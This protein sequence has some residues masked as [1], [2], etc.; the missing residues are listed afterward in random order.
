M[1]ELSSSNQDAVLGRRLGPYVL[2]RKIASGGMGTVY[3][4]YHERLE[5]EVALKTLRPDQEASNEDL[6]RFL[7]EAR[8]AARLNHPN[9]V[10]VFDVGEDGGV[11]YLAMELVR[12]RSL[13]DKLRNEGRLDPREAL[14]IVAAACD[15]LQHAHD[16]GILHRDLKPANLLLHAPSGTP[17]ITD[18]GVA[19]AQGNK[20]LT[21]TGVA[22]GTPNYMSPEQAMGKNDSLDARSDVWG[23]G[24]ILYELLTGLPPFNRASQLET[25]Q[26]VVGEALVPP[27]VHR[28]E[29]SA[30]VEAIVLRCLSKP[31]EHRYP[32]AFELAQDLR[33]SLRGERIAARAEAPRGSRRLLAALILAVC[34]GLCLAAFLGGIYVGREREQAQAS[35]APT[36]APAGPLRPED[37]LG[38]LERRATSDA[39]DAELAD[40]ERA[41]SAPSYQAAAEREGRAPL[42]SASVFQAQA[43]PLLAALRLRRAEAAP[44]TE[45]LPRLSL[46]AKAALAAP[47]S[48]P[49]R[50][51]WLSLADELSRGSLGAQRLAGEL[52]EALSSGGDPLA[53]EAAGRAA[54]LA[55]DAFEFRD[56]ARLLALAEPTP[57]NALRRE[58]TLGLAGDT[59]LEG[60]LSLFGQSDLGPCLI[61]AG[62]G[63]VRIRALE[64]EV[65]LSWP[66]TPSALASVDLSGDGVDELFLAQ[67]GQGG[68]S[69]SMFSIN[70]KDPAPVRRIG[71][72]AGVC[73]ELAGGSLSGDRVSRKDLLLVADQAS[74]TS[75]LSLGPQG[76]PKTRP[77]FAPGDAPAG[78]WHRGL[79]L[80]LDGERG[81]EVV[82][83]GWHDASH[84][85][86]P[87]SQFV[88]LRRMGAEGT[89]STLLTRL[90]VGQVEDL[91]AAPSK[92]LVAVSGGPRG[93]GVSV[94]GRGSGPL[95]EVLGHWPIEGDASSVEQ[96]RVTYFETAAGTPLLLRAYARAGAWALEA[97]P[98]AE[99]LAGSPQARVVSEAPLS[100]QRAVTLVAGEADG[101][102]GFELVIGRHVFGLRPPTAPPPAPAP[103]DLG[104]AYAALRI[105]GGREAAEELLR[106]LPLLGG[107]S[108]TLRWLEP[109]QQ[110]VRF[111]RA[112]AQGEFKARAF[113]SARKALAEAEARDRGLVTDVL[114]GLDSSALPEERWQLRR[115]GLEAAKRLRDWPL[116]VKVLRD[117][118]RA[119]RR[120]GGEH[121]IEW[122]ARVRGWSRLHSEEF[123]LSDTKRPYA[124]SNPYRARFGP[125]GV[126]LGVDPHA[127][128]AAFVALDLGSTH[129][130]TL[131]AELELQGGV[132][133]G[134]VQCG[135]IERG[136]GTQSQV[137]G[138]EVW[139]YNR[140]SYQER[141]GY[142]RFMASGEPVSDWIELHELR[143]KLRVKLALRT[144]A[145]GIESWA[146]V[147]SGEALIYEGTQETRAAR[148]LPQRA[149]LGILATASS[150]NYRE[151]RRWAR[152]GTI[153]LARIA[154][155]TPRPAQL[156]SAVEPQAS[157]G[158]VARGQYSE[159][160]KALDAFLKTS[161]ETLARAT[162]LRSR[163]LAKSRLGRADEALADLEQA[164]NAAPLRS[165]WWLELLG[166]ELSP[167]E[168]PLIEALLERLATTQHEVGVAMARSLRGDLWAELP[169]APPRPLHAGV[170][171][172]L[173]YRRAE[174]DPKERYATWQTYQRL[175]GPSSSFLPWERFPTVLAPRSAPLA[176]EEYE[177]LLAA[178]GSPLRRYVALSRAIQGR[179]ARGA[180]RLGLAR[181]F[182]EQGLPGEAEALLRQSEERVP[183]AERGQVEVALAEVY[184]A[185]DD[186]PV[187]AEFLERAARRGLPREGWP[188]RFPRLSKDPR[189][190]KLFR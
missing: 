94:I 105:L 6:A 177:A 34:L 150:L 159:A 91:A 15:G 10:P 63:E 140:E 50:R 99:V 129:L 185:L 67:A 20:R 39:D 183:E 169:T 107:A 61:S 26:A 142:L 73:Y 123:L 143:G 4:A 111:S 173:G 76:Q 122:E 25:M 83:A 114:A 166:P 24:A 128:E 110:D 72:F 151:E 135:L 154:I 186:L 179:P 101:D 2:R 164:L 21:A 153:G 130:V 43:G 155:A 131:E 5:R 18:F 47:T 90:E 121:L 119:E 108:P 118:S 84:E 92:A 78:H 52:F 141:F 62:S 146:S 180:A 149:Y 8:A 74:K 11:R 70:F 124:V 45:R 171:L 36:Q 31:R 41:L 14:E 152:R 136:E 60:S 13:Y 139:L 77:V 125:G 71:V 55:A 96:L 165:L 170:Q 58:L 175:L 51:A 85:E 176:D 3:D 69:L 57:P 163:A 23:M 148:V 115:I 132:S 19:R 56:A 134:F 188:E 66:G 27:R 79:L 32:S 156:V 157:Q 65:L 190:L 189:Y 37:Y 98:L 93:A 178:E 54:Q 137:T 161:P 138:C 120:C 12:G 80:D 88:T 81:D 104:A 106:E 38:A 28:P 42:V 29:L 160:L 167:S 59:P 116:A 117:L 126:T 53:A 49:S 1:D 17:R 44:A 97:C 102:P 145:E 46:L 127:E 103:L 33:R 113:V 87:E 184:E 187:A 147:K 174:T 144:G 158:L 7:N 112:R 82:L 75:I 86:D 100:G 182:R 48:G 64:R 35:P 16:K 95:P 133:G 22:L 68:A 40:L 181:L 30:D 162:A 172:Y 109:A 89:G 168:V 9:V